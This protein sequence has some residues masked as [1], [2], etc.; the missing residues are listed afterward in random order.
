MVLS[1]TVKVSQV[2]EVNQQEHCRAKLPHI[3]KWYQGSP[4]RSFYIA[5][6]AKMEY[7]T[8]L[9][10]PKTSSQGK[11]FHGHTVVATKA[12]AHSLHDLL[13]STKSRTLAHFSISQSKIPNLPL[14]LGI[15]KAP[16][17]SP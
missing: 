10:Q 14:L 3:S 1:H 13:S 2:W 4:K 17:I 9:L 6:V 8:V 11:T 7:V 16:K 5:T 15:E 12:P